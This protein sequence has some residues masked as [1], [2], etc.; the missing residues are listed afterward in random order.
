MIKTIQLV[1]SKTGMTLKE[2][3]DAVVVIR[4][5]ARSGDLLPASMILF[6]GDFNRTITM[7]EIYRSLLTWALSEQREHMVRLS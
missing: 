3:K 6:G 4:D 5:L 2:A 1:R 7:G